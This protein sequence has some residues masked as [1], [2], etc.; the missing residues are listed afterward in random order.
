MTSYNSYDGTACSANDWLLNQ[1][2]KKEWKFDGFVISDA[3]A[4]GGSVVLHNTASDYA[5]ASRQAISGGLD[6][7]FQTEYDHYK[8]FAGSLLGANRDQ[9]RI[10]DAVSRCYFVLSFSWDCLSVLTYPKM[11]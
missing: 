10:D 11:H 9:K 4:T 7:I 5:E 2:L 6:V 1:K 3:N 8:L